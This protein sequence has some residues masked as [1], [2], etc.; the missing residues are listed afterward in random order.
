MQEEFRIGL[1][2]LT[3]LYVVCPKCLAEIGFDL[4]PKKPSVQQVSCPS[5]H[6]TLLDVKRQER[7]EFTWVTFFQELLHA[8]PKPKMFFRVERP[9]VKVEPVKKP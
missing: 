2:E 4:T 6:T 7:F 1:E 8:D 5:C 9:V 3:K